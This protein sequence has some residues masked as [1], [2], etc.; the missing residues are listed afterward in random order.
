MNEYENNMKEHK[1]TIIIGVILIALLA[2]F[3]AKKRSGP[4]PEPYSIRH[5][6][7]DEGGSIADILP[8]AS[9]TEESP[10][11]GAGEDEISVSIGIEG[12]EDAAEPVEVSVA[13]VEEEV[14]EP[15]SREQEQE[16][17]AALLAEEEAL[18]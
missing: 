13:P 11:A 18:S 1:V 3:V 17:L 14:V 6:S 5:I 10:V 16:G 12:G 4:S 9:L 8:D 15:V 2:I 7:E